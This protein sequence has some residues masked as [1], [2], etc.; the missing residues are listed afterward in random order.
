MTATVL[1]IGM[2]QPTITVAPAAPQIGSDAPLG[3]VVA[4]YAASMPDGTAFP[5]TVTFGSP[6]FDAGGLFAVTGGASGHIIV[7][8]VGPGLA[9]LPTLPMTERIT[10]QAVPPP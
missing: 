10:L 1:I 3:T 7:S 9:S 4:S 6:Y 8:P 5:G 2:P